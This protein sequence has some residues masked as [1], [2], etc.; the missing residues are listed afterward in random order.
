MAEKLRFTFRGFLVRP[1]PNLATATINEL[2]E[3]EWSGRTPS[4]TSSGAW[5]SCQCCGAVKI[6]GKGHKPGCAMAAALVDAYS[7]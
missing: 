2:R 5:H 6:D 7:R 1:M 4:T 3:A